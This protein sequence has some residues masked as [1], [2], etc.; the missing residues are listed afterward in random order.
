MSIV[1]AMKNNQKLGIAQHVPEQTN[2]DLEQFVY[3][4]THDLKSPLVTIR[5]YAAMLR[6][7]LQNADQT[8][9]DEDL[10]Y[11]NKAA[12]KMQQLLDALQQYSCL[13]R[14]EIP[15]QTMSASQLVGNC[16][17][18]LAG[19]LHQHEI[20][21][22]THP[23]THQLHG[24]PMHFEC[25]WQNLIENAVKYRDDQ[26]HPKIEIGVMQKAQDIVFYV[27]D[28]GIGIAPENSERIY[29]LYSQLNSGNDGSGLGL[30]LVKKIV[31]I[32][33]GRVWVESAGEGKGSCFMFTLPDAVIAQEN[34]G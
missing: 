2:H 1:K 6:R 23:L 8:Q 31:S 18:A 29:N 10:N 16:L 24:N 30:A 13:A 12:G 33:Q 5:T 22:I 7:D 21:I 15:P 4:V 17:S 20:Q 14:E 9:I 3:S 27:R 19:I 32:Y 25:L 34:P 28:N 11:I 26:S